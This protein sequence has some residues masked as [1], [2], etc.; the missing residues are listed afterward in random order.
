MKRYTMKYVPLLAGILT[1]FSSCEHKDL[2]FDHEE[3][4]PKSEIRV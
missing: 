4:A 3:H 2:C 1:V